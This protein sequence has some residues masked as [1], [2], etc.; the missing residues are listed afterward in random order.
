DGLGPGS[1]DTGAAVLV[2]RGG[3]DHGCSQGSRFVR[4]SIVALVTEIEGVL[5]G[6]GIRDGERNILVHPA[7]LGKSA[8][9]IAGQD[10]QVAEGVAD[11]QVLDAIRSAAAGTGDIRDGKS[12]GLIAGAG[13]EDEG[14]GAVAAVDRNGAAGLAQDSQIEAVLSCG[15]LA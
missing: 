1:L 15:K 7:I 13:R 12:G 3:R 8:V 4:E 11:E 10:E 14:E 9:A 6:P 2:D 5:P